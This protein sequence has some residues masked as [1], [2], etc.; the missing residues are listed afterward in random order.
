LNLGPGFRAAQLVDG[1]VFVVMGPAEYCAEEQVSQISRVSLGEDG[2]ERSAS[3]EL[4]FTDWQFVWYEP[5]N[6]DTARLSGGPLGYNGRLV[7]DTTSDV[8]S[9]VT[10]TNQ[11]TLN[12][13]PGLDE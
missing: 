11:S 4:P 3:L 6:A 7:L 9:V 10:Y 5:W 13:P 12:A 2:L 8:P 1:D